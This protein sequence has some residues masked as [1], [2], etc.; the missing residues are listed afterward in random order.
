MYLNLDYML[1]P[2]S[3]TKTALNKHILACLTT[4][5]AV[6]ALT[7]LLDSFQGP[8]ANFEI[9]YFYVKDLFVWVEI[10]A[11]ST[12]F[13]EYKKDVTGLQI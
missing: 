6:F 10:K 4:S 2:L 9:L 8:F 5:N 1:V 11:S 3:S 13:T 12:Y 7:A